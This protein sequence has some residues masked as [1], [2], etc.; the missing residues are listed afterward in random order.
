[1]SSILTAFVFWLCLTFGLTYLV[2]RAEIANPLRIR[3]VA[4]QPWLALL[5]SCRA[6]TSF[7]TAQAA[8]AATLGMAVGLGATVPWHAW[9]YLP[10]SAGIAAI[11]MI[12]LIAFTKHG[13]SDAE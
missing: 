2:S 6:C 12:D 10:P 1:M 4:W 11:G 9:L 3:L 7:W 8:A 5:L 13:G